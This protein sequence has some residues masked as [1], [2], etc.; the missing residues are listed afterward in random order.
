M[1]DPQ[2]RGRDPRGVTTVRPYQIR[3]RFLTAISLR[4]EGPANRQM[5][6]ELD[7]QLRQ[8]PQFFADA[9]LVIDLEQAVGFVSPDDLV[10]LIEHLR[11]RRVSVFAVQGGSREQMAAAATLGLISV[12]AGR[13]SGRDLGPKAAAPADAPAP[14]A[15]PAEPAR[16]SNRIITTPVRSGQT[17][18]AETGDLIV[19]GPVGSGAELIA[20]GNIHVYGH[21]RG[22]ASAGVFGDET[23]RIFCQSLEAELISIAG[24]YRTSESLD[25]V[26]RRKDVQV[27]L[28]GDRLCVEAFGP[29][30]NNDR[31]GQ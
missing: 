27:F 16:L 1:T 23:A 3:G 9:P 4:L 22:R 25:A 17:V 21:L 24:L 13:D 8:T 28:Q 31:S 6:A 20:A 26:E 11:Y 30:Q 19:V 5:L 15:T 10:G 7:T 2:A 29:P 18:V 14:A 12:P